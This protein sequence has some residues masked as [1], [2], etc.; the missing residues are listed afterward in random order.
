VRPVHNKHNQAKTLSKADL[1]ILAA[2][3]DRIFPKTDTPGALECGAV[4][5]IKI[6]LGELPDSGIHSTAE[7]LVCVDRAPNPQTTS[8]SVSSSSELISFL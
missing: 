8:K 7:A 3:A 2:T 6:A 1:K 4:D 5:Y